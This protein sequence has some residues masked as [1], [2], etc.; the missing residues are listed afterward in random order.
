MRNNEFDNLNYQKAKRQPLNDLADWYAKNSPVK[1]DTPS[2][3]VEA[4]R[5]RYVQDPNSLSPIELLSLGMANL[6]AKNYSESKEKQ[7]AVNEYMKPYNEAKKENEE[8]I[9]TNSEKFEQLAKNMA[10]LQ[11]AFAELNG[12]DN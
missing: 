11:K 2:D 9:S 5:S 8:Y 1:E 3:S 4:L 7:K 10:E 12:G 6:N